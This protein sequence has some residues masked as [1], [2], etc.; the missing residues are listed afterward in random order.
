MTQNQQVN[1][2]IRSTCYLLMLVIFVGA[3]SSATSKQLV[4]EKTG[5]SWD[6]CPTQ[7]EPLEYHVDVT[8][9]DGFNSTSGEVAIL[10]RVPG[11]KP[12]GS[13]RL[14]LKLAQ[15]LTMC[16]GCAHGVSCC[17]SDKDY[18]PSPNNQILL[19]ISRAIRVRRL[20]LKLSHS[21]KA[22]RK[23]VGEEL[24]TQDIIQDTDRNLMMVRLKCNLKLGLYGRLSISFERGQ[25]AASDD[26]DHS[27]SAK[28]TFNRIE[29]GQTDEL[30]PYLSSCQAQS[31]PGNGRAKF[32]VTTYHQDIN[33]YVA[34]NLPQISQNSLLVK[35]AMKSVLVKTQFLQRLPIDVEKLVFALG[36]FYPTA[37]SKQPA[38]LSTILPIIRPTKRSLRNTFALEFL[39][40]ALG[41]LQTTLAPELGQ[42]G[43][44][45]SPHNSLKI[46]LFENEL[47]TLDA[48]GL[49][50]PKLVTGVSMALTVALLTSRRWVT[51]FTGALAARRSDLW[52]IEGLATHY[53]IRMVR[54]L[55]PEL[56]VDQFVR[57][58]LLSMAIK[59]D[60]SCQ[61][62]P[63]GFAKDA[64]EDEQQV[65]KPARVL[66]RLVKGAAILQMIRKKFASN[67]EQQ[68]D[69][70]IRHF[71]E[72]IKTDG[73]IEFDGA[74]LLS[75][76]F[77]S[78]Q[79][80]Q[81]EIIDFLKPWKDQ[82][83]FPYIVVVFGEN[84]K[85]IQL[86]QIPICWLN[87]DDESERSSSRWPITL[88]VEFFDG[89]NMTELDLSSITDRNISSPTL[90]IQPPSLFSN[91]ATRNQS[92]NFWIALNDTKSLDFFKVAY[93]L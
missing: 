7:L 68:F 22:M 4:V 90:E 13:S 75:K 2:P 74:S 89:L 87:Y 18:Q 43:D 41:W 54:E 16:C 36:P 73:N 26:N 27:G 30:F 85:N 92:R 71:L 45:S 55:M 77:A 6:Q 31:S 14:G 34:S 81:N 29:P 65:D 5:I 20:T 86:E 48:G 79:F 28:S 49:P 32:R 37:I 70:S 91:D 21:V 58:R 56:L 67:D 15:T 46:S 1:V 40:Q 93:S 25:L 83:G 19:R 72:E 78:R 44:E 80:T 82:R 61:Y 60:A 53:A 33:S 50:G 51:N 38:D 47:P 9:W 11:K 63:I 59:L 57:S 64:D 35:L 8:L 76:A 88:R 42:E 10:F 62:E 39:D 52:I 84:P 69:Q 23:G 24:Q 12:S 17:D 3:N 66:L